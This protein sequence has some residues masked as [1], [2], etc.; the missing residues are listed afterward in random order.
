MAQPAVDVEVVLPP[1][2]EYLQKKL[3]LLVLAQGLEALTRECDRRGSQQDP[4]HKINAI[5]WLATWLMR[6]NPAHNAEARAKLAA[7]IANIPNFAADAGAS[8]GVVPTVADDAGA[9]DDVVA[10]ESAATKEGGELPQTRVKITLAEG[11]GARV[12]IQGMLPE[13]ATRDRQPNTADLDAAAAQETAI[14]AASKMAAEA[15]SATKL[16]AVKRGQAAR[17][18][19]SERKAE[20]AAKPTTMPGRITASTTM[21]P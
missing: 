5:D 20:A 19:V 14:E 9:S 10:K 11:G 3:L 18:E 16:Q 13:E 2:R 21:R 6:N 7:R 1:S 4:R 15:A 12:N 17:K 8:D